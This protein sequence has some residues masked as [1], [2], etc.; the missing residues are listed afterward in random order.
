V[1][2]EHVRVVRAARGF[3]ATEKSVMYS[4][5][6][7][8]R[9][10]EYGVEHPAFPS[11]RL[12]AADSGLSARRMWDVLQ[13]L[14]AR[15]MVIVE[16]GGRR[17]PSYRLNLQALEAT[18]GRRRH[19]DATSSPSPLPLALPASLPAAIDD[20]TSSASDDATSSPST[21]LRHRTDDATSSEP[22]RTSNGT[23]K[24]TRAREPG[25]V[26]GLTPEDANGLN[27]EQLLDFLRGLFG[28]EDFA[29]QEFRRLRWL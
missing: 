21:T 26:T 11:N 27:D 8:I 5:A 7:R 12:L 10:D 3:R 9:L 18:A 13:R 1:S 29:Q 16:R 14:V 15:G 4:L 25:R 22:I 20:A 24:R 19:D 17:T 2:I 6:E 28:E 23:S